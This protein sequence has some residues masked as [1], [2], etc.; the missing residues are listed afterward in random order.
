MLLIKYQPHVMSQNEKGHTRQM[1]V[2]KYRGG[3]QIIH[4]NRVFHYKPYPKD[5]EPSLE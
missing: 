4:F 1:G 3:P 5:P 2:S